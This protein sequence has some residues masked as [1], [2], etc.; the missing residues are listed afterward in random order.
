MA[1]VG[2]N[3][4]KVV[5]DQDFF[6]QWVEAIWGQPC[7]E[8]ANQRIAG[9]C[10]EASLRA[11]RSR[12]QLQAVASQSNLYQLGLQAMVA[13]NYQKARSYFSQYARDFSGPG[14]LSAM[15][16]SHLAEANELRQ[17]LIELGAI[18][19]PA[20][21]FPLYLESSPGIQQSEVTQQAGKRAAVSAM[22]KNL[23]DRLSQ[24]V[25]KAVQLIEKAIRLQPENK[26]NYQLLASAYLI[27]DN[28]YMARG[29]LQGRYVPKF[30]K[31]VDVELLLAMT[32]AIEKDSQQALDAL[33][34]LSRQL[35]IHSSDESDMQAYALYAN[36]AAIYQFLGQPDLTDQQWKALANKAQSVSNAYLFRLALQHLSN[37]DTPQT[38]FLTQ[39]PDI[40]GLTLGVRKI[41]DDAEHN[42]HELW[43][44]GELYH[45]YDYDNG[46]QFIADSKGK[47]ISAR[48]EMTTVEKDS[49][50]PTP[51]IGDSAAGGL[52]L[53]DTADRVLKTLGLPDRRIHLVSGDYLAYDQ[54]GLALH[55]DDH[56]VRG[57]FLY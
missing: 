32:S 14:V 18:H 57:W 51:A 54:Y 28:S 29:I 45:V 12:A 37:T 11:K 4:Y 33:T 22:E 3:P 56:R 24:H 39:A 17:Q 15:G 27:D 38:V 13:G 16:V 30:G 21:Y 5:D 41:R 48:R 49:S 8:Q 46:M 7:D 42:I 34:Q 50:K 26:K 23:K 36:L 9:A 40:N 20:Y 55:I 53:G 10:Q 19:S 6:T 43:I 47:I 44:E 25:V 1:S 35:Q 52:L 31:D 2:F